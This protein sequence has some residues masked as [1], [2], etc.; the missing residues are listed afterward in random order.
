[1]WGPLLAV[2]RIQP[3]LRLR[4]RLPLDEKWL[5]ASLGIDRSTD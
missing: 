5:N 2:P 1:V 3:R 4:L